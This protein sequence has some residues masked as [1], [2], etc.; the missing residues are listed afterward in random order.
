MNQDMVFITTCKLC[1]IL[2]HILWHI[3]KK[4]KIMRILLFMSFVQSYISSNCLDTSVQYEYIL[5]WL[6]IY[7]CIKL[8]PNVDYEGNVYHLALIKCSKLFYSHDDL[9]KKEAR[10]S[11]LETIMTPLSTME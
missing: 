4:E 10:E 9:T 3:T 2:G 7:E 5:W 1:N 6:C 11:D 8:A